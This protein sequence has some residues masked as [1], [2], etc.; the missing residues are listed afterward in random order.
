ML[1][2]R[3]SSKE[4][5]NSLFQAFFCALGLTFASKRSMIESHKVTLFCS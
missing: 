5:K 3:K 1:N 4:L 2:Y